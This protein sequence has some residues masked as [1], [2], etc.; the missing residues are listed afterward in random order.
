MSVIYQR[1]HQLSFWIPQNG[2]FRRIKV[3]SQKTRTFR[4]LLLKNERFC[5]TT[6]ILRR[7]VRDTILETH[8][9]ISAAE[10]GL[11]NFVYT[12][13]LHCNSFSEQWLRRCDRV[14]C[15]QGDRELSRA[16]QTEKKFNAEMRE[17][18]GPKIRQT[19]R[20]FVEN[21][22]LPLSNFYLPIIVI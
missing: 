5:V 13:T 3:V 10:A 15:P 4:S 1:K 17:S 12:M 11:Y 16:H 21:V 2:Q 22:P 6:A 9:E 20:L 14:T 18:T 7:S 8:I 19:P